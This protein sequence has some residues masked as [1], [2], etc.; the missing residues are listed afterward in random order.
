[1]VQSDSLEGINRNC[2]DHGKLT[3]VS[4]SDLLYNYLLLKNETHRTQNKEPIT[5]TQNTNLNLD[6]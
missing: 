4:K 6:Q 1:M 2:V 5:G 3:L